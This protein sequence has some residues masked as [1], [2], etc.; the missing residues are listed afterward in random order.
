MAGRENQTSQR[1]QTEL[2]FSRRQFTAAA[3]VAVLGAAGLLGGRLSR[4]VTEAGPDGPLE[5]SLAAAVIN[6]VYR[7]TAREAPRVTDMPKHEFRGFWLST[8]VNIDWPSRAGLTAA[9]QQTELRGWLDLARSLNLNAVMLQVRPSGDVF[10]PSTAGEPWS[11]Y[12]TG[13]QGRNPGYDPLGYAISQA[14]ARN[15]HLHAWFNPFRA[16][17]TASLSDLVASHPARK[18][19]SWTFAYGGRR[20]YNPGLPAVRSFIIK[21]IAEVVAKY[22][23]DGI[24]LDDYFYPYPVAGQTIADSAAYNAYKLPGE[25]LADFRRR[26]VNLFVR[27]LSTRIFATKP[28]MLFGISPFGIWR[29]SSTDSRGSAT[30]GFQSYDGI[31]ADSRNWVKQGWLDYVVPQLY[32]HQGNPAADYNTLVQWWSA[33]VAGTNCKLYIGEAAYKVGDPA[34]GADWQDARELYDHTAKCRA[35]PRVA[36]Q[37]YFSAKSVRANALGSMTLVKN[38]FYR[39]VAMTPV[40][41]HLGAQRPYAPVISSATWNGTGVELVWRGAT[42]GTLPRHYAIYRWEAGANSTAY[43][44]SQ[45][46]ALRRVHFRR[47]NPERFVDTGVARGHTYWY[48]VVALSDLMVESAAASAIFIRA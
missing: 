3:A 18:N 48:V 45:A 41:S 14:H 36:G 37:V 25:S 28:R 39:R 26:S 7:I 47:G 21:V 42:T 4:A 29:N 24:H 35:T 12:L 22:D 11:R 32:W 15:L 23:V 6:R 20:Y 27:D 40:M 34:Q 2:P 1:G 8:V 17:M 33:Q 5:L 46:G 16:S 9:A 43:I 10:W 44:P 38:K 30:S 31:F 13:T 19:P